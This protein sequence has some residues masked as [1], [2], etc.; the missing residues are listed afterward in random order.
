[1]ALMEQREE[2]GTLV[3]RKAKVKGI[4]HRNGSQAAVDKHR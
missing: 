1:M 3:D 4:A 2:K